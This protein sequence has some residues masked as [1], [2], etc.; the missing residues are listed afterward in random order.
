MCIG[1]PMQ[2]V[3]LHEFHAVCSDGGTRHQVD[4]S[5]VGSPEVGSW[6]LVFLGAARE[7]LDAD[8]ALQ[9]RD[10]VN[11]VSR[12]MSGDHQIEHLFGDLIDRE[13]QAPEHLRH[14]IK[15]V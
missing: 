2:V 4:T 7:V 15:E 3:E 13:P 11:A 14:L 10:A 12:V 5:L 6:L 8:T 1:V 9:M